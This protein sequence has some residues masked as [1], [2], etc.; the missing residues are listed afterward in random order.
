MCPRCG[1]SAPP[2]VLA[3][4]LHPRAAPASS[5]LLLVRLTG[6]EGKTHT[7]DH[8]D[9]HDWC[10]HPLLLSPPP[11]S[12]LFLSSLISRPPHHS[13]HTHTHARQTD[14]HTTP[15]A[16][17]MHWAPWAP[18]ASKHGH[19]CSHLLAAVHPVVL[20]VPPVARLFF[21]PCLGPPPCNE[22]PGSPC[23]IFH[24]RARTAL[25]SYKPSQGFITTHLMQIRQIWVDCGETIQRAPESELLHKSACVQDNF[26]SVHIKWEVELGAE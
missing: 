18:R 10:L 13:T 24:A 8:Q 25:S 11:L 6:S 20:T 15:C 14:A 16:L 22:R 9:H 7:H 3:A 19:T 17:V 26:R 21:P 12:L 4:H 5:G 23:S 2:Y 1:C